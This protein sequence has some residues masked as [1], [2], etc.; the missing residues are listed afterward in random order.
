[1]GRTFKNK[2]DLREAIDVIKSQVAFL[3]DASMSMCEKNDGCS[4]EVMNGMNSIFS[5]IIDQIED[6]DQ[7]IINNIY[8]V[9]EVIIEKDS[10]RR[11]GGAPVYAHRP[12]TRKASAA[13]SRT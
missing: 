7:A 2:S 1:M 10:L 12:V 9:A 3:A 11:R 5:T 4:R 8:E 6:V 13:C